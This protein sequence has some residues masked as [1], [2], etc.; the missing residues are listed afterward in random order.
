LRWRGFAIL[1]GALEGL[2]AALILVAVLGSVAVGLR[3]L[4][5]A[6]AVLADEAFRPYDTLTDAHRS[7]RMPLHLPAYFPEYLDW[8]PVEILGRGQPGRAVHLT[9]ARRDSGEPM[10]WL[11]QWVPYGA[12]RGREPP[13][14][15]RVLT[16]ERVDL[17][18]GVAAKVVGYVELGSDL[19]YLLTWD[20]NGVRI[21]LTAILPRDEILRMARSIS[22]ASS[23]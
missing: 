15:A 11:D 17:G 14:T 9:V 18:E 13:K 23:Y 16:R 21:A 2:R 8:P 6:S 4:D 22:P 10:L 12:E 20:Q 7:T 3:V 19:Y 5:A 1:T